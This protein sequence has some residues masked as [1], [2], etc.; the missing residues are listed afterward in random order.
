MIAAA[1]GDVSAVAISKVFS[2]FFISI[3]HFIVGRKNNF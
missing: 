2:I 1:I 3:L